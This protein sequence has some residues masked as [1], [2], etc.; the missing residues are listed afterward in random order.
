VRV[1][2]EREEDAVFERLRT[3]EVAKGAVV[4]LLE[5]NLEHEQHTLAEVQQ[6]AE[7]A[8]AASSGAPAP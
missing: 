1:P 7:M 5:Q 8:A 6:A 2:S 4:E 3:P